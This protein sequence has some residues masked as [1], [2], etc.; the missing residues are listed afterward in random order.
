MTLRNHQ[1]FWQLGDHQVQFISIYSSN[2]GYF[3]LRFLDF[4]F[5]HG[6]F[7]VSSSLKKLCEVFSQPSDHQVQFVSKTFNK[8]CLGIMY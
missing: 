6:G 7:F 3:L 2:L 8:V 4:I 1:M 5:F